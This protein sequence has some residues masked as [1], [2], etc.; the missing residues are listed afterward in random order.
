MKPTYLISLLALG[1]PLAATEW[2]TNLILQ[3]TTNKPALD[4]L[5]IVV[6]THWY[7]SKT[8]FNAMLDSKIDGTDNQ[9][10]VAAYTE[11]VKYHG[12]AEAYIDLGLITD[13]E[14][15]TYLKNTAQEMDICYLIY[16]LVHSNKNRTQLENDAIITDIKIRQKALK[17]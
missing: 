7:T 15:I 17:K 12:K 10:V 1:Q 9:N 13:Q 14:T 16:D 8:L 3:D 6:A 2:M 5:K 11:F 4:K